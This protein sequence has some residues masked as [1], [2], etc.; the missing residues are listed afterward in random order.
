MDARFIKATTVLPRQNKVCGRTLRPFCL[1]HRVAFEAI[2][3][4]FL[5]PS[6]S[7]FT[8]D[9]VI[10]AV[11]IMS[12]YEKEESSS[13]LSL[14]ETIE[15]ILMRNSRKRLTRNIGVIIG[16][17]STSCSYPKIWEKGSGGGKESK[18]EKV[19]W[20]LVC[21]ANL[22]RNGVSLEEAW[23]MPEGEAV[24]MSVASSIYN[25]SKIDILSTDEEKELENFNE[26]IAAYK[27][28]HNLS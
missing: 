20:I 22:C 28:K 16:V 8:P 18:Y 13:P 27:K 9:D 23:T 24:W 7:T 14:R 3:S 5:S 1:R 15:L 12:T 10:N 2:G 25:G 6:G 21:V 11:R 17:I 4:P 19:P 26:R